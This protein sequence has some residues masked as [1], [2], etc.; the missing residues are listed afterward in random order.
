M[1][2]TSASKKVI[3]LGCNM[4]TSCKNCS[5][6]EACAT[7]ADSFGFGDLW[8]QK[9][10]KTCSNYSAKKLCLQTPC[11]VGDRVYVIRDDIGQYSRATIC[12]VDAIHFGI[13]GGGYMRLR[14]IIQEWVGNRSITYKYALSSV[15]RR[16]FLSAD[17]ADA[18]IEQ[19]RKK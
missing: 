6:Y 19:K 12:T 17:E 9:K 13:G 18:F 3:Y 16:V 15:G 11:A 10:E 14:P 7:W 2:V 4:D 5:H 1:H 8:R